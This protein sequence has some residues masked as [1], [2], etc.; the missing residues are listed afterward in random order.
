MLTLSWGINLGMV[1]PSGW[2]DTDVVLTC[3]QSETVRVEVILEIRDCNL[4][5]GQRPREGQWLAQGPTAKIE[6]FMH[7]PASQHMKKRHED[8]EAWA[9]MVTGLH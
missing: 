9:V 7:R 2:S 1:Q 8:R 4:L 5:I 6:F 3:T